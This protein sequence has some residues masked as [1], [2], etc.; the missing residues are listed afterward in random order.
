MTSSRGSAGVS[1][2]MRRGGV[3]GGCLAGRRGVEA[4]VAAICCQV[5]PASRA[6][7]MRSCSCWSRSRR[8]WLMPARPERIAGTSWRGLAARAGV[9]GA[10]EAAAQEQ[11]LAVGGLQR[12][13]QG[14]GL[15]AVTA[16]GL[17]ELGGERGDDI[18]HLD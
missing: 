17:S 3:R 7:A 9:G 12:L 5:A 11:V 13:A 16:P 4:T 15:L 2:L 14:G 10:A 1:A 6:A 18:A 8:R